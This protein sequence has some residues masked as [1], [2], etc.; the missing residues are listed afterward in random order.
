MSVSGSV[1]LV[2][3][4]KGLGQHPFDF[5]VD[6]KFFDQFENA[7]VQKG[8]ATIHVELN[9]L[10][11]L[12]DCDVTIIGEVA[13]ECDRCLDEFYLPISYTGRLMVSLSGHSG[14][15]YENEDEDVEIIYL[16]PSDD[17]LDITQYC[18]ESIGLSIPLQKIHPDD[19]DGNSTCNKEMLAKLKSLLVE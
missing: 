16:Q 18:Y 2:I 3:P 1:R 9:K 7:V 6:D 5:E 10:N 11:N 4:F 13:V 12:L 15:D 14:S 17:E 19:A 8:K